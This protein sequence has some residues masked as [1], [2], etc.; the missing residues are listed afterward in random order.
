MFDR[1]TWH[2]T[3]TFLAQDVGRAE[4]DAMHKAR[5]FAGIGYHGG[6]KASGLWEWGRSLDRQGA[7]VRGHN[8]GNLGYYTAGGLLPE[9]GPEVGVDTRTR[10]QIQTQI[11][12]TEA[13]LERWPSIRYIVGHRDLVATQCPG[14]DVAAWWASVKGDRV[15][16]SRLVPPDAPAVSHPMVRRGSRVKAVRV[17]Q[18]ALSQLGH[19]LEVDGVFGPQTEAT[20]REFQAAAG[21]PVDGIVG[22][23]T[24]AALV[25]MGRS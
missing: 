9:S 12:Q 15:P 6:A 17:L 2:Y 23:I 20:V 16:V 10:E 3:A 21:L 7:H 18:D 13:A 5:G 8:P 25:Q 22:P 1:L 14:Y 19:D 24:W 4:I 11:E